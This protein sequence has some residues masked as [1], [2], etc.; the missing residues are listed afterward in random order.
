MRAPRPTLEQI[1]QVSPSTAKLLLECPLKLAFSRDPRFDILDKRGVS[2][3]LGLVAHELFSFV[4]RGG[5]DESKADVG[6]ALEAAW[7]REVAARY[8]EMTRVSA[9]PVPEPRRWP[10]YQQVRVRTLR[11]LENI[12]RQRG[13]RREGAMRRRVEAEVFARSTA[14]PIQG[15]I[16]RIETVGKVVRVIDVKTG[17][18]PPEVIP[19]AVRHQLLLYAV[20]VKD[21]RGDWPTEL[22][23]ESASGERESLAWT[24]DEALAYVDRVLAARLSFNSTVGLAV[25]SRSLAQPSPETCRFCSFKAACVAHLS[26][27]TEEWSFF[28]RAVAGQIRRH[29]GR[30]DLVALDLAAA[31]PQELSG[32]VVRILSVPTGL[33]PAQDEVVGIAELRPTRVETQLEYTQESRIVRWEADAPS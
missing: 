4:A 18:R 11:S 19:A 26:E 21:V 24:A 14:R 6:E 8:Q 25:E 22:V 13:Q 15:R 32:R 9:L 2:A 30:G 10:R 28:T 27:I 16:D 33:A 3:A 7:E 17:W 31:L 23:V 12:A 29:F 20:L 1:D 5:V